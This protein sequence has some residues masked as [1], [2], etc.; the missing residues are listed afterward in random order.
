[1]TFLKKL[2]LNTSM[3]S[4]LDSLTMNLKVLNKLDIRWEI[5]HPIY[6]SLDNP[7]FLTYPKF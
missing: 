1:M 3:I 7:I 6:I 4:L 5:H 2:F